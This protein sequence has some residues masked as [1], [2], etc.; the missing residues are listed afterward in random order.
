LSWLARAILAPALCLAGACASLDP[1]PAPRDWSAPVDYTALRTEYGA[2][3]DFEAVCVDGQPFPELAR[4]ARDSAWP[5]IVATTGVWLESCPVD[6]DSHFLRAVALKEVGR[7]E[8]SELHVEWYKGLVQ[9]VLESGD[10]KTPESAWVIISVQ[11]KFAMLRVLRAKSADKK[12]LEGGV[13][14]LEVERQDG[15]RF[16]VY[17]DSSA[18]FR[19]LESQPARSEP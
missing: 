9:S 14:A 15:T 3:D 11:E 8:E 19:R 10:G 12:P 5:E 16:V 7:F 17:F 13:E 2:R 6:I 4:Q 1:V 18:H